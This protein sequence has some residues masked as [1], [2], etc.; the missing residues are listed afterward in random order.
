VTR[1]AV[2]GLWHLGSV[3]AAGLAECGHSVVGVEPDATVVAALAG[4][5]PPVEEP[6]LPELLR[7]QI[8]AGRLAFTTSLPEGLAGVDACWIAVDTP[9]DDRDEADVEAVR[10]RVDD[11][12]RR[13]AP[14]ILGVI[15]AQV[16]VGFTAEVE[17]TW[18]ARGL[19]WAYV[20]ENLRLGR[21]LEAFRRPERIVAGVREARDRVALQGVLAPLGAPIVWMTP[22]SAEMTKHALNAFLA[23]SVAFINEVA[24]LCERTGADAQEVERGLRTDGRVGPAAYLSPGAPYGGGTLARD[25]GLLRAL[26]ARHAVRT[27]LLDGAVASNAVQQDW[28]RGAVA[29]LVAGL[30]EPVVAVLGL[31]YKPG[32]ST[33]RRSPALETCAWLRARGARVRAHDPAVQTRPAGLEELV[34]CRTPHDALRG[35][36]VA[37]LATPWPEYRALGPDDVLALMQRPQVVDAGRFLAERLGGDARITYV[38][39]GRGTPVAPA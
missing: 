17:R 29:G 32:T 14:G 30:P 10:Q 27:P 6:G 3:M 13:L 24:R 2:C 22:E 1:I 26:G 20:P 37:W 28:V 5:R 9:V 18:R 35:A 15:S 39:V 21:A 31:T 33:L 25:V 23:T 11:V 8:A 16:P 7:A 34:L 38:A 4:G 12:A 19:R 36:D